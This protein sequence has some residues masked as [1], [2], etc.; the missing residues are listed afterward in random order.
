VWSERVIRLIDLACEEDLGAAGD[1][2]R[3]LISGASDVVS[4]SV[5]ARQAGVICGLSLC[6]AICERFSR[7]LAQPLSVAAAQN[8]GGETRASGASR[9]SGASHA[10]R[11]FRDGDAVA[12]GDIVARVRGPCAAVLS[13]ERTLLNFLARMSGVATLTRRFVETARRASAGVQILDTRKT[14]PGWREL[15]KYAVRCGGGA[16]HR[17]GLHDAVLLKDNHLAGV[18][19]ERLAEALAEMLRLIER[20]AA[21]FVEVE[22][23]DLAHFEQVCRVGG[24]DVIL[25]D[26]F[27]LEQVRAAVLR[28]DTLG[29]RGR[30]ALEASGGVTLKSVAAIAATGVDRVSVGALT[31][32]AVALDLSLEMPSAADHSG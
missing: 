5:V 29:L 17:F 23:D 21:A 31:H 1:L 13:L 20:G 27:P 10:G 15:D 25:L 4:A 3:G 26:N 9:E 8:A 22:V 19:T 6:E 12:P 14:I 28:R 7:R 16:N 32:S 24:V 2:T 30:V 11:A 18:R